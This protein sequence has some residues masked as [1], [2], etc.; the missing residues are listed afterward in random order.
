LLVDVLIDEQ[1]QLV[2]RRSLPIGDDREN[3]VVMLCPKN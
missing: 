1:T 2:K 3:H